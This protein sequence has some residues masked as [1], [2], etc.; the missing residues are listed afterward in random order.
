MSALGVDYNN[1]FLLGTTPQLKRRKMAWLLREVFDYGQVP[2]DKKQETIHRM[3][4][5]IKANP[6]YL[7]YSISALGRAR[8]KIREK[9]MT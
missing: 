7:I 9:V 5:F 6:R 2:E 1:S 3:Y 4:N 8:N